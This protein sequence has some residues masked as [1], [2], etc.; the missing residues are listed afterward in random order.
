MSERQLKAWSQA[1]LIDAETAERIRTWEAKNAKPLGLW[2]LIGLGAL[3]IGL[4]LVSVVAAN[5]NEI[6]GTVRLGIHAALMAGLGGF[7]FWQRTQSGARNSYFDDAALFILAT[8]GLTFFGHIGQVY[9]TSSPLWQPFFAWMLLFTPLLLGYGRGWIVAAMWVAGL[10]FT[11]SQHWDWYMRTYYADVQTFGSVIDLGGN[12]D[13]PV[14]TPK[15]PYIYMGI[16]S[17]TPAFAI[18]LAAFT[19]SRS[20]RPDFWRKIEQLALVITVLGISGFQLA[21]A[22]GGNGYGENVKVA[23]VQAICLIAVAATVRVFRPTLSGTATAGVL[24]C[25]AI[26]VILAPL[27]GRSELGGGILFMAFWGSIAAAAL[28]ASWRLVFQAAVAVVAFRLIILSFEL[29]SDLLGSGLGL[30]LAGV[31]T[32]G[33]AWIAVRVSKRYAPQEEDA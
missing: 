25:G 32:L 18:A 3:A 22:L 30:I 13:G 4:G 17:A 20:G 28:Y 1:G 16:V 14:R 31:A 24:V 19:R 7:I 6:P 21:Y 8:L 10:C 9:Q 27:V 2:A 33:I 11:S 26:M 12:A 23:V 15:W 29:A 5:W